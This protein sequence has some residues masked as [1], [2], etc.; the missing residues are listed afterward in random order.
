MTTEN[1]PSQNV[2]S[3]DK[4][5]GKVQKS[6]STPAQTGR[7]LLAPQLPNPASQ[8]RPGLL[9][10]CLVVVVYW[11]LLGISFALDPFAQEGPCIAHAWA[12]FANA[13]AG[14]SIAMA[15]RWA[16]HSW[17]FRLWVSL[18]KRDGRVAHEPRVLVFLGGLLALGFL[19]FGL[20]NLI[21]AP[22]S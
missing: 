15:N 11:L 13:W 17:Y 7:H 18:A 1:A 19:L 12:G 9:L 6:S 5:T 10:G 20:W 21:E 16:H 22:L 2:Y 4:A 14:L 3:L 8:S